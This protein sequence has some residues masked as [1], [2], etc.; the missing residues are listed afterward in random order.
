MIFVFAILI[1]AIFSYFMYDD[2]LLFRDQPQS[3][4]EKIG[5]ISLSK[6]DVRM[7]SPSTF[8]WSPASIDFD[9][10]QRDTI[11]T[12]Q[13]SEVSIQL[14]DGS[15]INLKENSLVTLNVKNGEMTLDLRYGDFTGELTENSQIKVKAGKEEYKLKAEPSKAGEKSILSFNKSRTGRVDVKLVQGSASLRTP[16]EEKKLEKEKPVVVAKRGEI[17]EVVKP[18]IT[19]KTLDR[20][21]FTKWTDKDLIP[22]EWQSSAPVPQ[23]HVEVS[24]DNTFAELAWNS[25]TSSNKTTVEI[26]PGEYYWRVKAL[27][28][29]GQD[30]A[31][32]SIQSFSI[33]KPA[34]PLITSPE[35]NKPLNFE[36]KPETPLEKQKIDFKI[37]WT[38]DPRL[39]KFH[40]QIATDEAFTV[41][42][43]DSKVEGNETMSPPVPSGAYFVR[44][45]AEVREASF[46]DWS[47]SRA[48]TLMVNVPK[49]EDLLPP[50]LLQTRL[51]FNPAALRARN[52]ATNPIPTFAWAPAKGALIYKIQISKDQTF[53]LAQTFTVKNQEYPWLEYEPGPS[54]FRVFAGDGKARISKASE[55]GMINVIL[56]D[57]VLS[58]LKDLTVNGKDKTAAP[59]AQEVSISWTPVPS[60]KKYLLEIDED[61][62]F[63]NA[64][65][66]EIT[67]EST[68]VTLDKPGTFNFR[69]QALNAQGRSISNYSPTEDIVYIYKVPLETPVLQEPYDKTTLF[70]QSDTEPFLWLEWL[71]VKDAV[72][73][74]VELSQSPKFE[75]VTFS[76]TTKDPRFLLKEKIPYGKLYW[77]VRALAEDAE[78]ESDWTV[79]REF[80]LLFNKNEAF[81]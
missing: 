52:P 69:V 76:A 18:T 38:S 71:P 68:P 19:L 7:K 14:F 42:I 45:R 79:V 21:L 36:L 59:P 63:I 53:A 13:G 39:K 5:H 60:A 6:N 9:I 73:Y 15:T 8:S 54:Y 37:T 67:N 74:L 32:S 22:L 16:K 65:K 58:P 78:M 70:L 26:L 1:I 55:T 47:E 49:I 46:G 20:T 3:T 29:D 27:H 30:W 44:V 66:F 2:S 4:F 25:K 10:H 61:K 17:K 57:P 75:K 64:K 23:F 35:A 72:A 31:T 11:F 81:R 56:N 48:V 51:E 28:H 43:K 24:K 77:R 80:S 33:T 62:D 50:R 41:L 34:S 12:G 40:V